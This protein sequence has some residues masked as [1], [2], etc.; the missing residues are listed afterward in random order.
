MT[1]SFSGTWWRNRSFLT[2]DEE[3]VASEVVCQRAH[4]RRRSEL[5]GDLTSENTTSVGTHGELMEGK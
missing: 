5:G 4:R 3:E 2:Q 1:V